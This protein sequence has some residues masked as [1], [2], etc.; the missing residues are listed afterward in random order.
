MNAVDT[1]VLIYAR[2]P[3]DC[4][5][6]DL[7][8]GSAVVERTLATSRSLSICVRLATLKMAER[9]KSDQDGEP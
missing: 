7:A 3:R 6:N 9:L 5:E 4:G 2:D 1:N 8:G